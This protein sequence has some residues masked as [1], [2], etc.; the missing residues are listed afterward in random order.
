[1]RLKCVK[2]KDFEPFEDIFLE[3]APVELEDGTNSCIIEPGTA[4]S[5]PAGNGMNA[6][7]QSAFN[8]LKNLSSEEGD[9]LTAT[10]WQKTC[11]DLGIA[12]RTF[13]RALADL[14]KGGSVIKNGQGQGAKYLPNPDNPVPVPGQCQPV[15]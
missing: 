15:P 2:Q 6:T 5:S 9:G 10:T 4:A 1:M 14:V 13:Y 11:A 8:I 7:Q 12:R 3:L